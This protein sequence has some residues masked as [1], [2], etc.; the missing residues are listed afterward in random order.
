MWFYRCAQTA[1]E[2]AFVRTTTT[3]GVSVDRARQSFRQSLRMSSFRGR[4]ARQQSGR[5]T[6]LP[7][8]EDDDGDDDETTGSVHLKTPS[9]PKAP[10]SLRYVTSRPSRRVLGSSSS[11][12]HR[13]GSCYRISRVLLMSATIYPLRDTSVKK[14]C[15][16]LQKRKPMFVRCYSIKIVSFKTT[17]LYHI[18]A[19]LV[20]RIVR[21]MNALVFI[22]CIKCFFQ[23]R[24]FGICR[25]VWGPDL[26]N[27][28]GK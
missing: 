28:E 10:D 15:E 14:S 7:H 27:M 16:Q 8:D 19:F 2:R 20:R 25:S 22:V 11:V 23:D 3:F 26:Q 1:T 13:D 4:S 21:P 17:L 9:T 6:P 18:D 5:L 12:P 24:P